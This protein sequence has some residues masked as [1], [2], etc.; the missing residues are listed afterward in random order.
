MSFAKTGT[1]TN[2]IYTPTYHFYMKDHLGSNRVV[3]SSVGEAEQVN[4]YYPY[5]STFYG[6]STTAHRFK[7][8]GK[9]LDKMHGLDWYDSSARYYDHVLGRFHQIDPHA[10]KY[11]S[12]S[13]YAYCHNNP[14]NRIDPTGKDGVLIVDEKGHNITVKANYYVETGCRPSKFGSEVS[15]Y[16]N[17]DIMRMQRYNDD[18]KKLGLTITEGDFSGYTISFDLNFIA[19][20]NMIETMNASSEDY[21]EGYHIGNTIARWDETFRGFSPR[22]TATGECVEIGGV[23]S[24]NKD[25]IMNINHDSKM[26]R[27]HEIFHTFGFVDFNESERGYGIM[28]YPPY[29]PGKEDANSLINNHFLPIIYE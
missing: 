19:G 16:S 22:E 12:W 4:H 8:C 26:N 23:T 29:Q 25:I 15:G 10:E 11:Y 17:K 1:G 20:G 3:A 27:L 21:Y 6:E 28:N 2:A 5:G 24:E 13:P 9:E 7:Y 18:L 14:M